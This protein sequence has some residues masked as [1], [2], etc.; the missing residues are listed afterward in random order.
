MLAAEA[1]AD[2]VVAVAVAVPV[3]IIAVVTDGIV[4]MAVAAYGVVVMVEHRGIL[5]VSKEYEKIG[6]NNSCL[7]D[8]SQLL[9]WML[10]RR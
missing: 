10:V 6:I 3:A 1:V 8:A 2:L 7:H 9:F 5:E 4:L